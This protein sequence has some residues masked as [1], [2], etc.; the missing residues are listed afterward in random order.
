MK[1]IKIYKLI[2]SFIIDKQTN[3]GQTMNKQRQI[4]LQEKIIN[5]LKEIDEKKTDNVIYIDGKEY[6]EINDS[7]L[8]EKYFLRQV[9]EELNIFN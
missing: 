8:S 2:K 6:A 7:F 4:T 1:H 3:K 5:R 9:L